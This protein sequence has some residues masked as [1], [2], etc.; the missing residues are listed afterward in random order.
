MEKAGCL[1]LFTPCPLLDAYILK[2]AQQFLA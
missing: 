1:Q 2:G